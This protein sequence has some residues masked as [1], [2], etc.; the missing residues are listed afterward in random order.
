MNRLRFARRLTVFAGL[1]IFAI[2]VLI[3]RPANTTPEPPVAIRSG[4]LVPPMTLR[5]RFVF[6]LGPN[7][8]WVSRAET[9]LFGKRKSVDI[10]MD[11]LE[12][13][14][15]EPLTRQSASDLGNPTFR[16]SAGLSVWFLNG[17]KL[18]EISGKLSQS[19]ATQMSLPRMSTAEGFTT[20]MFIGQTMLINGA[21]NDIGLSLG[22]VAAVQDSTTKLRTSVSR[23]ELFTRAVA[24]GNADTATNSVSV[25]TNIHLAAD[26]NIPNG[27][28]VFVLNLPPAQSNNAFGL[29]IYPIR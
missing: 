4:P 10:F 22:C 27:M 20:S 5:D 12:L 6:T 24:S 11:V 16:N 21:K 15:A 17:G 3:L 2:A 25:R 9:A 1:L 13:P 29:I 18:K 28:G 8:K 23:T 14:P 26:F 19:P 7:R